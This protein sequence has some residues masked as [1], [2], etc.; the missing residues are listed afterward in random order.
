[1]TSALGECES[2]RNRVL[3]DDSYRLMKWVIES[4]LAAI[5]WRSGKNGDFGALWQLSPDGESWMEV[6]RM[7]GNFILKFAQQK[8]ALHRIWYT[9]R[10]W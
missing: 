2:G 8:E 10:R 4:S 1:M 9:L 6:G 5:T 3:L 7:L